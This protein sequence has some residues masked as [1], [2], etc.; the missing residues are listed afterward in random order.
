MRKILILAV[1]AVFVFAGDAKSLFEQRYMVC[2]IASKPTPKQRSKM[3]APPAMGVMYHVKQ[4]CKS[5]EEARKI[6]SYLYG[7]FPL[8]WF[9]HSKMGQI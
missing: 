5:K 7:N 2:H 3:V 4:K 1:A 8:N 9:K 6:A